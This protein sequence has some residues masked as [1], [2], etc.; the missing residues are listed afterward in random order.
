MRHKETRSQP[1]QPPLSRPFSS[2]PSKS[3]KSASSVN[4]STSSPSAISSS[5]WKLD[6][7]LGDR[8]CFKPVERISIGTSDQNAILQAIEKHEA[9]G[10][11]LIIEG[12]HRQNTWPGKLFN[13][14]WLQRQYGDQTCSVRDVSNRTD[15]SMRLK[16]YIAYSRMPESELLYYKDA[17][18]PPEWREWV[19]KKD[20]IP[21]V[22]LPHGEQDLFQHLTDQ[23]SVESLMCYLGC[24]PTYTPCHKDLCASSGQ[25]IMCYAENG[26]SS[27]W[28]MTATS[29]APLV[30][31]FFQQ[32]LK[33]EVDWERHNVTLEQFAKAPFT[34]YVAQ[35]KVGDLV[36]VPPRSCHQVVNQGGL[37]IKTSWSRMTIPGLRMALRYELP[38]YRRVCRPEQYR[39]KFIVFR[40]LLKRAQELRNL[41]ED[42]RPRVSTSRDPRYMSELLKVPHVERQVH[43]LETLIELFDAIIH[44]EWTPNHHKLP[45]ILSA[46]RQ[47]GGMFQS[48]SPSK[49][50]P[51]PSSHA[52]QVEATECNF[53]CDFCGSDIFQSFFE[54]REC[55]VPSNETAE[56]DIDAGASTPRIGSGLIIC[57]SC[58]VEGRTCKCALMNAAQCGP[59]QVL[60]NARNDATDALRMFGH[61]F[62][63]YTHLADK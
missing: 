45:T 57:P 61:R 62:S 11:P 35:Q 13:V 63:K 53:A 17:L 56:P 58:Y 40:S 6:D 50:K 27:F 52:L 29:D 48:R 33:S 21:S 7:I 39:V 54:C 25:N 44:E 31:A 59:F 38:I 34:V 37:T 15:Q 3:K 26:G 19:N 24:G 5:R 28:F 60:F 14:D 42:D 20:G 43:D 23:E 36:L 18:C 8:Q 2:A 12:F 16:Q 30:G 9:S 10:L 49:R 55:S 46:A 1:T 51:T 32:E 47:I 41:V 22:L 4:S